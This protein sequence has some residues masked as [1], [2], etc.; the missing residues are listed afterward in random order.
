MRISL[1]PPVFLLILCL[2]SLKPSHAQNDAEGCKDHVLFNRMSAYYIDKCAENYN[3][4]SL[5]TAKGNESEIEG[6]VTTISYYSYQE[7]V[8]TAFQIIKNY[9]TA[10]VGKGG[11]KIYAE[12]GNSG[13]P[14]AATFQ[15]T[16]G[17]TEYWIGL[18][19]MTGVPSEG[20]SG[21]DL[22]IISKTAM[23]QEITANEMLEKLNSGNTLTL[24]INFETAKSTIKSESTK[25]VDEIYTML[26]ENPTIKI[27]IEGHTDNAGNKT[28]NQTL[29]QQRAASVKQALIDKGIAA[30]RITATGFGQ[31][32]P[33]A[34][35]ESEDGKARN[36]RVEIRKL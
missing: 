29:S 19:N 7:K 11:K 21:Y 27:S 3:A 22:V 20:I 4:V 26:K 5:L 14:P 16:I 28:A 31:E 23:Q 9:E 2:C 15:C 12:N 36:R 1:C 24:Y 17:N 30:N 34:D 10:I 32:K 6:N 35:N 18:V 13:Q 25:I 33:I 8:P